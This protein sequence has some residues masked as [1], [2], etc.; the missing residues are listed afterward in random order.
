MSGVWWPELIAPLLRTIIRIITAR[1]GVIG[2]VLLNAKGTIQSKKKKKNLENSR[3]GSENP[4]PQSGKIQPI[5]FKLLAS[6]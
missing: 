6:F 5:F 2:P 1:Y 4:P 3:L